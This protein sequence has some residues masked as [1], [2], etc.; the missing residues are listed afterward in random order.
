MFD[1]YFMYYNKTTFDIFFIAKI[2][3]ELKSLGHEKSQIMDARSK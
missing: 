1:K 3:V 2:E